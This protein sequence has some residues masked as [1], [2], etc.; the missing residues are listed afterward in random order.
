MERTRAATRRAANRLHMQVVIQP[1]PSSGD[2]DPNV[3]N[4]VHVVIE[5]GGPLEGSAGAE[6]QIEEQQ[7]QQ[8]NERVVTLSM[9]SNGPKVTEQESA[10]C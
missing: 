3:K 1:D 4:V 7:E 5:D 8:E 9:D 10:V 2:A 6:I